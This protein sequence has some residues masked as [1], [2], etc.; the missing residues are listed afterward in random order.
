L[1][2]GVLGCW[3]VV[4]GKTIIVDRHIHDEDYYDALPRVIITVLENHIVGGT[5]CHD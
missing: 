1:Y 3:G 2:L 4:Y 5:Y